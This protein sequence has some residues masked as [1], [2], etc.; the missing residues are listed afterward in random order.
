MVCTSIVFTHVDDEQECLQL[1]QWN[2]QAGNKVKAATAYNAACDYFKIGIALLGEHCWKT[3]YTLTL[4]LYEGLIESE[5]LQGH[6]TE[7]HA[8]TEQL[9]SHSQSIYDEITTHQ[10][11]CLSLTTN[12]LNYTKFIIRYVS[13]INNT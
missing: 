2:L 10:Y 5:F 13:I 12:S 1:A 11:Y 8:W 9:L 6:Y 3:N 4:A 7:Q